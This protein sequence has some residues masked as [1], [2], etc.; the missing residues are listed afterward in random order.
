MSFDE[1]MIQ[2]FLE[3][4]CQM[5]DGDVSKEVS[6][7]EIGGSMGL[8]RPEAG[9]LA[10]ELI[11]DGYAEL[12][13]LTGGISITPAGLRLLNLDTGGHGEGQGED[14]F[15]LG[16]GEAV[17]PEGVEA[18]EGLVEEIR[19]AVGEGRFTYSQ[20]EELVIDLKTLQIQ[21]L[22]SRPKTNIVREVLRSL[23]TPLEGKPETERL[24]NTIIKMIG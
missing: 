21:L 3:R 2:N 7:Y 9:A 8:D 24:K 14:Q 12:K 13:N 16:D 19:K 22:S 23:A 20:V 11:I 15:V 10:E 4:L 5:S 17:T 1:V 6:M 18:I